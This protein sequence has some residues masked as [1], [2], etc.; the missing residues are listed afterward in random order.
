MKRSLIITGT[1][2]II[3]ILIG[4]SYQ[5]G[6]YI[7]TLQGAYTLGGIEGMCALTNK[8][9]DDENPEYCLLGDYSVPNS[10]AYKQYIVCSWGKYT[11]ITSHQWIRLIT[12]YGYYG[13]HKCKLTY[14]K[15][16]RE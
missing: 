8:T 7:G 9:L 3:L 1:S 10:T 15:P 12:D 14:E 5:Y 6:I 4:L 11:I 16:I 2:I 13:L